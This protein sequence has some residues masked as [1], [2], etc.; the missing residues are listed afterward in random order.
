M[1]YKIRVIL[2]SKED[3]IRDI[4]I[5]KTKNLE[6]LHNAISNAFGFSGREMAAFYRA[7]DDWNQGE[8][9]PLFDMSDGLDSKVQMQN[10]LIE[11]VLEE[12]EHKLIY[13]YDFFTMWSFYIE[14]IETDLD[15]QDIELPSLLFSLGTI[16]KVAPDLQF[17]SEDLSKEFDEDK[18]DEFD[19]FG[20][21]EYMNYE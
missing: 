5:L 11:N 16:P 12:K 14:L 9:F 1:V 4:A 2:N 20:F 17:E 19:E 18:D 13:V 8:E 6:N 7:D 15:Q 3:V 21:D 10:M